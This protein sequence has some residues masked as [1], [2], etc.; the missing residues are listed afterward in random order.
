MREI[1]A[2]WIS[3]WCLDM[4]RRGI[5]E[6]SIEHRRCEAKALANAMPLSEV[7]LEAFH[8]FLERRPGR[9]G[10]PRISDRTRQG[11]MSTMSDLYDFGIRAGYI[12]ASDIV[13]ARQPKLRATLP[14]PISDANLRQ[15]I[16]YAD[17]RMTLWLMLMA[18]A[19]L[20]TGEIAKLDERDV[21]V[22]SDPWKLFVTGKGRKERVVPVHPELREK[23]EAWPPQGPALFVTYTG[24]PFT[25]EGVSKTTCAYLDKLGI[26]DRPH[27]I[28]HWFATRALDSCS[29]LRVVQELLGHANP[30]TTAIYTKLDV[31][32][33]NE[34][35]AAISL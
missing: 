18:F 30:N 20:R 35:V 33:G 8:Q 19:G 6:R 3:A 10:S 9:K 21:L 24:R 26:R 17:Q 11:W 16:R 34:A 13:G 32:S 25:A 1:D 29:N 12:D 27:S 15:A 14:R 23:L 31:S 7:R 5:L 22:E 28:R 4:E 2:N